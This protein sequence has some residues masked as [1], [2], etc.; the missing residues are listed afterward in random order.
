MATGDAAPTLMRDT[1][2]SIIMIVTG[3]LVGFSLLLG[4]RKFA[5]QYM[6]LFGISSILSRCFRWRLLC[7]FSNGIAASQFLY[8]SGIIGRVN[9]R[10]DVRR[11]LLI[12]TKTHQSLF[13]YEHEDEGDD[14]N[15]H[16]GKTLSAQ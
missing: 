6:N 8:R 1:L 9:F 13:I 5:T 12:Q 15:P 2:Y 4:G 11:I 3:G 7:W 10:R 16:H 14:G